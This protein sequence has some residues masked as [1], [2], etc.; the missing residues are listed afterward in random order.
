[1]IR[2][3]YKKSYLTMNH[4]YPE[5]P[6]S[7]TSL[8]KG[9][10]MPHQIEGV[11]FMLHREKICDDDDDEN[12]RGGILCDEPGLGKTIQTI[13]TIVGSPYKGTTLIITPVCIIEQFE[14]EL[15][16]YAPHLNV[17]VLHGER[18]KSSLKYLINNNLSEIDII[19]TSCG[20]MTS[21]S[22]SE[23]QVYNLIS[24][25]KFTRIII[26]EGH[27]VR[28]KNNLHKSLIDLRSDIKFILTGTPIHNSASDGK[29][30]LKVLGVTDFTGGKTLQKYLSKYMLRRKK[31]ILPVNL[32]EPKIDIVPVEMKGK[33]R[34]LYIHQYNNAVHQ[35]NMFAFL[36]NNNLCVLNHLI[37]M[38]QVSIHPQLLE[39]YYN[40]QNKTDHLENTI[41]EQSKFDTL[42][43]MIREH[44][45]D[46]SIIFCHFTQEIDMIYEQLQKQGVSVAVYDGR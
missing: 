32:N 2:C 28:N 35:M 11:K 12:I 29:N 45:K 14:K 6:E 30:I 34:E 38:R 16:T 3:I 23:N 13:A 33:E 21:S 24:Q 40:K 19:I 25:L 39:T 44:P 41:Q 17:I 22:K 1:M 7:I 31:N 10:L 37:R 46:K 4:Q 9:E 5:L 36:E 20:L 26:D 15:K 18:K 42:F 8:F 27:S 43:D